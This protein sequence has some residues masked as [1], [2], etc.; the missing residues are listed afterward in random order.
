MR[1][2]K[3]GGK[4]G[5]KVAIVILV[6]ITYILGILL[7][8]FDRI[9]YNYSAGHCSISLVSLRKCTFEQPEGDEIHCA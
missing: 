9:F 1:L 3:H 6:N 5:L 4:F 2:N 7:L 8:S